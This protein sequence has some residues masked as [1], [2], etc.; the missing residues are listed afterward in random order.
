MT[1]FTG[2]VLFPGSLIT[3]TLVKFLV[4]NLIWVP[5]HLVW[6]AAGNL[7]NQL[8]LSPQTHFRINCAMALAMVIVVAL[9]INSLV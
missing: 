3:E 7:V 8:D 9:A 5:I 1:W 4:I 2:F 6:L